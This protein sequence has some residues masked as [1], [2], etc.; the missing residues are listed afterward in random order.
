MREIKA[1][2]I[3][4]GK[5]VCLYEILMKANDDI[6]VVYVDP[7]GELDEDNYKNFKVREEHCD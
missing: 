7:D 1:I 2:H 4:S 6:V 5:S 3:P